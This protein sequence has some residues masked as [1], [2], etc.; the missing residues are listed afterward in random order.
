MI[1]DV[2]RL[3]SLR[4]VAARGTVTAA[5]EAL[6]YTPSAVSQQLSTLEA[7]V[8]VPVLERR[9]RNV[10]LTDAGRLLVEHGAAV[11][12][13]VERAEAAVAELRDEPVGPVRIGALA[14]AAASIVPAALRSALAAH[15][16]L[17][18]SVVVHPL[19]QNLRELRL[20]GIDIAVD[21]T[22]DLAPGD[23]LADLERTELLREPLLLLS[24]ATAPQRSVADAAAI[25]WAASPA[26]SACGRS[27]RAITAA[28]GI[29][30]RFA[31]ETDDHHATVSL[32]ASG[33]AV[34]VLPALA[35]RHHPADVHVEVVPNACRTIFAITR[36][37][38]RTRPAIAAVVEHLRRAAPAFR[39]KEAICGP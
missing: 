34:A 29:A 21:Q 7:E 26:D 2:R 4:E 30:P 8:G 37:A 3:R 27:T 33:L 12:A 13:A 6:G 25:A 31:Y 11:L 1:S 20:G 38:T 23:D 5:A 36:P 24:P 9:G 15:P 35:V 10:A 32:V 18:P 28:H 17:E 39:P 22:Y 19:D 16:A 14:S